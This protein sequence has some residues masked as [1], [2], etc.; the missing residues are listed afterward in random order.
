MEGG[1]SEERAFDDDESVV[2]A[3]V[4][5]IVA[6]WS[7]I[8]FVLANRSMGSSQSFYSSVL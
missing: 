4:V 3:G 2:A 1:E 6:S 5:G 8:V 7:V